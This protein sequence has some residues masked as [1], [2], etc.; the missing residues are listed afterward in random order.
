M[1]DHTEDEALVRDACERR[2]VATVSGKGTLHYLPAFD[3]IL[4]RLSA[5]ERVVEDMRAATQ[6]VAS[7][8]GCGGSPICNAVAIASGLPKRINDALAVEQALYEVTKDWIWEQVS[9]DSTESRGDRQDLQPDRDR[10]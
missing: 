7:V 1:S 5:A 3:R 2:D 10:G 9:H 6:W 8:L 4:A